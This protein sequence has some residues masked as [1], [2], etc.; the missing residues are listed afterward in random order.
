MPGLSVAVSGNINEALD[1]SFAGTYGGSL[2]PMLDFE[3]W[4]FTYRMP[5]GFIGIPTIVLDLKLRHS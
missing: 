5:E 4:K 3:Y 1:L 2:G